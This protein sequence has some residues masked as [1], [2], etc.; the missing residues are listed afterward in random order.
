MLGLLNHRDVTA[1]DISPSG[2]TLAIACYDDVWSY[3]VVKLDF[4]PE[5]EVFQMLFERCYTKDRKGSLKQRIKYLAYA[6]R[7]EIAT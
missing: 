6:S 2:D 5:I 1:A 3:R 4:T 7:I